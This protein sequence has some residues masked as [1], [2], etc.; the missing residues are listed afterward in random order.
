M[1]TITRS[2]TASPD[3]ST[4]MFARNTSGLLAAVD[5]AVGQAV[6]ILSAGTVGLTNGG[7]A[8]TSTF[9]GLAARPAKTGQPVTVLGANCRWKYGSGLTPGAR[10]Y[11]SATAGALDDAPTTGGTVAVAYAIDTTDIMVIG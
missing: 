8:N 4:A 1:A 10:Y 2:A 3:A 7:A 9:I 11:V 6:Y 5:I